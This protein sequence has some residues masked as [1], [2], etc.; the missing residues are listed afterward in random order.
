M[1]TIDMIA[2]PVAEPVTVN[3]VK[4][5]LGFGPMQDSDR[6][7]SQILN[8]Q[9][10]NHI[11]SA[12]EFCESWCRRVFITQ[13][14]QLLLDSFPSVALRY[15]R[16]GYPELWLPK[17]PFQ[18]V[19]FFTYVDTSGTTQ[20]L[21]QDASYGVNL[22]APFYGY[23]LSRGSRTQPARLLPP[24]ARPWAPQRMVPDNTVVR[25]RCGYGGPVT[26]SMT[27][28]SAVLTVTGGSP[29]TFDA[30][31]APLLPEE[32]GL[33]IFVPGAGPATATAISPFN[34]QPVTGA[35]ATNIASVSNGVATLAAQAV[36]T[37]TNVP[38][39]AGRPVPSNIRA[40][41]RLSAAWHYD[42]CGLSEADHVKQIE[43]LLRPFRNDVS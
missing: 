42:D 29:L 18:S 43:R 17:P 21:T 38:G 7:A 14:W 26:C 8:E 13:T 4:L 20:T 32:T 11:N 2:G 23:Q 22:A 36:N 15:D 39:W 3:D 12:R 41:I 33:P 30:D 34:A 19:V 1:Q 27:A 40:A 6:A 28:G 31:D 10:R 9:L 24:W 25:F 5:Q 16:N 35:L 37:V